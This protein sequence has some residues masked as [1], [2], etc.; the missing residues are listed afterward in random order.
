MTHSRE[1]RKKRLRREKGKPSP[2]TMRNKRE[3][4]SKARLARLKARPPTQQPKGPKTYP[5]DPCPCG[6]GKKWKRCCMRKET[7]IN[8]GS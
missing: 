8:V 1:Q 2:R 4:L 6:S 7:N 3:K 5:N